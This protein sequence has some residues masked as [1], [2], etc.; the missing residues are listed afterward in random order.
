VLSLGAAAVYVDHD[1]ETTGVDGGVVV[2]EPDDE[3]GGVVVVVVVEG[4]VDDE[5]GLAGG[6]V[7]LLPTM[8]SVAV[9]P[10]MLS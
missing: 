1:P 4:G 10:T 5:V 9:E 8:V 7:P 3:L 2:V 6:T